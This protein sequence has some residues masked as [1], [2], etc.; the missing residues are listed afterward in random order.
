[1]IQ[2]FTIYLFQVME[3]VIDYTFCYDKSDTSSTCASKLESLGTNVSGHV[4]Y[5]EV[6]FTLDE[7]FPVR[8]TSS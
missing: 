6:T 2:K 1:M 7:N 3:K 4:C 8:L 5:C